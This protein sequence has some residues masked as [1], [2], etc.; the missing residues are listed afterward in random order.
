[1]L[2]SW[3]GTQ[4]VPDDLFKRWYS[5]RSFLSE[6]QPIVIHRHYLDGLS[7]VISATL[8]GFCDASLKAQAAVT[9]LCL[10]TKSGFR[11]RFMASKTRVSPLKELTIPKLELLSAL[12]LARL[13]RS[14]T[15]DWKPVVSTLFHKLLCVGSEVIS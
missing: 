15:Q 7:D 8:C 4:T 10:E 2:Q 11:V 3:V 6:A 5:L 1:M 12:L 14:V 9:Y 13:L